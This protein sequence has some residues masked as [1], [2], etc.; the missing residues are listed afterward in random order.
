MFL[1]NLKIKH[2]SIHKAKNVGN[3]NTLYG[4]RMTLTHAEWCLK[5][6]EFLVFLHKYEL[7]CDLFSTNILKLDNENLI[8]QISKHYTFI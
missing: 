5:V 3:V 1:F 7:N 2:F 8:K 6:C 4:S